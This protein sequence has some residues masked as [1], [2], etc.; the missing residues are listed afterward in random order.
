MRLV[1]LVRLSSI[2]SDD[3]RHLCTVGVILPPFEWNS[4]AVTLQGPFRGSILQGRP[5]GSYDKVHRAL[6][7]LP[8]L[9]ILEL[10]D[11]THRSP[12]TRGLKLE[13]AKFPNIREM[14]ACPLNEPGV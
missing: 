4:S 14:S 12:I 3:H 6:T 9:R 10:L 7:R 1:R 11:V 13:R 2:K 5:N 8:N